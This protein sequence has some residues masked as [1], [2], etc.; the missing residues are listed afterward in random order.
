MSLRDQRHH[1]RKEGKTGVRFIQANPNHIVNRGVLC[2]KG[3]ARVIKQNS[4]A[5]LRHPMIRRPGK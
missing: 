1:R 4:P 3:S 2:A 5:K